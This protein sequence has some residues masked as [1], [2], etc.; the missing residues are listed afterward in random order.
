MVAAL[1]PS[2]VVQR[3]ALWWPSDGRADRRCSYWGILGIVSLSFS[4]GPL[5]NA[6]P[7]YLQQSAE[8]RT[9]LGRLLPHLSDQLPD[10]SGP[11]VPACTFRESW[12]AVIFLLLFILE[13]Q[14]S[15]RKRQPDSAAAKAALR[16]V[17]WVL[18]RLVPRLASATHAPQAD[19]DGEDLSAFKLQHLGYLA[20]VQLDELGPSV[21][22]AAEA[23]Q[24]LTA[25]DAA[26]SLVPLAA[27]AWQQRQGEASPSPTV[28]VDAECIRLWS[29][30][31]ALLS[32]AYGGTVAAPAG[33][34]EEHAAAALAAL[35]LQVS[36][37]RALNWFASGASPEW[38]ASL[39]LPPMSLWDVTSCAFAQAEKV[40]Q[41]E[42][43]RLAGS[44]DP[45]AESR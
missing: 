13:A 5:A 14:Q 23:A 8:A 34:A 27:Q 31:A 16:E 15:Q 35:R 45:W 37:C 19:E 2:P 28:R 44:T 30:C 33:S 24:L 11:E 36:S 43:A 3:L 1:L 4:S 38:L 21:Q 6:T 10:H 9:A 12:T 22:S 7:H 25:A 20:Y 39:Q 41:A 29:Y 42:T 26:I 18:L 40:F 32:P 17:S